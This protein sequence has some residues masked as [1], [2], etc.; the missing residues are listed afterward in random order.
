MSKT[1]ETKFMANVDTTP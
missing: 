1:I